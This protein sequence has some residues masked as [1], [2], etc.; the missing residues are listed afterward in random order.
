MKHASILLSGWIYDAFNEYAYVFYVAGG[1][2]TFGVLIMFLVHYFHE[3]DVINIK[4]RA[5]NNIM[6]MEHRTKRPMSHVTEY[7]CFASSERIFY[8]QLNLTEL[9]QN[10]KLSS[11]LYMHSNTSINLSDRLISHNIPSSDFQKP[12]FQ[13]YSKTCSL[14]RPES[15]LFSQN[16]SLEQSEFKCLSQNC[17]LSGPDFK[18]YSQNMSLVS[19]KARHFLHNLSVIRLESPTL[20]KKKRKI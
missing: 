8:S 1:M 7:T 17:S 10:M 5:T 16:C 19:P 15:K 3:K 13:K 18:M 4:M 2:N 11:Y 14:N 12:R 9:G 6:V 20:L